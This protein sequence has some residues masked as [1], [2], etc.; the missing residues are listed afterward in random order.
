MKCPF[1]RRM[2]VPV[3]MRVETDTETFGSCCS[4]DKK[5]KKK[6]KMKK[7]KT[8]VDLGVT[9]RKSDGLGLVGR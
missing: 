6:Q 2:T 4:R 5:I 1:A 9:E 8:L 7:K 3:R